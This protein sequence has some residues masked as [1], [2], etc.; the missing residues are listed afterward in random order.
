MYIPNIFLAH[1]LADYD[2]L[3]GHLGSNGRDDRVAGGVC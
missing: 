2:Y 1:K 3:A